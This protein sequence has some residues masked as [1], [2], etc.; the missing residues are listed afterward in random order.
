MLTPS[1]LIACPVYQRDWI[2]PHWLEFIEKQDY[3][4][5]RIGFLFELGPDDD[6]THQILW[7]WTVSHPQYKTFDAQ[8]FM[9]VNHFHHDES[10]SRGWSSLQY[11]NMVTLRNNLLE[12]ASALSKQYDY[13]FSLDSDILLEDP[14]TLHKLVTHAQDYPEADVLSPLM[15]MTPYETEYPSSMTWLDRVGGRAIR[16]HSKYKIGQVFQ[17]DIVMAAVFMKKHVFK[18]L[19]YIWHRQGEDLGFAWEI[20]DAGY[21]SFAAWD[22]YCPH[23][24]SKALLDDYL[25]SGI[26]ARKP[27]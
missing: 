16:D 6:A 9:A 20:A 2:L 23:I 8:V 12:R 4:K 14:L 7:E 21:K 27:I 19:R 25:K 10:G 17:T 5:E 1:I 15:Y 24:M 3:P 11:Y 13:Y 22:I 18:N 26:D